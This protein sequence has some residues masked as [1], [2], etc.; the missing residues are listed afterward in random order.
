[1]SATTELSTT[2]V[3]SKQSKAFYIPWAL[4]VILF[5]ALFGVAV[6]VLPFMITGWLDP[7]ALGAHVVHDM[8]ASA[9]LWAALIGMAVQARW[10]QAHVGGMLQATGVFLMMCLAIIISAFA[11]PPPFI[12]LALALVAGALHPARAELL[13]WRGIRNPA[14]AGLTAVAAIPLLLYAV[15]Q[16]GLQRAAVP[17]DPHAEVGHWLLMGA[18]ALTILFLGVVSA[19]RPS[20]WRVPAWS[21]GLLAVIMGLL[22]LLHPGQASSVGATWGLLAIIWGILFIAAAEW[23]GRGEG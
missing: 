10:P 23:F 4:F 12:F 15:S 14:L 17:Q 19:T 3:S 20:G 13:S 6:P 5:I 7:A 21:A 2:A 16:I 9:L 18:Y 22:S 8:L 1:M 11:F